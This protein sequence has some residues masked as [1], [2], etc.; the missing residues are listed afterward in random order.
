MIG[1]R[2]LNIKTEIEKLINLAD[3]KLVS[4][5]E[6]YFIEYFE[7]DFM[8]KLKELVEQLQ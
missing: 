4:L 6:S 3:W 2:K 8:P 7:K 5:P 1:E